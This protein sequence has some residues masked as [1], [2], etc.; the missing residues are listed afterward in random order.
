MSKQTEDTMYAVHQEV[1][2]LGLRRQFDK[3]LKKMQTQSK[4]KWKGVGERWEY[5]LHKIKK[6][7]AQSNKRTKRKSRKNSTK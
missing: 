2:K 5:A 6:V 7:Y 1:E 4:W 3:Q